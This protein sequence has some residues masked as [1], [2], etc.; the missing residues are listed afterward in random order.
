MVAACSQ[1]EKPVAQ[2]EK[3][4]VVEDRYTPVMVQIGQVA[5]PSFS[6]GD[7]F[8]QLFNC[9]LV[10]EQGNAK[11]VSDS[12]AIK[13]Y[14]EIMD[15][16]M[17]ALTQAP[18]FEIK[19]S[20]QVIFLLKDN[21]A[22]AHVLVDKESMTI[23]D[24][25]FPK[26]SSIAKLGSNSEKFRQQLNGSKITFSENNFELIP[27]DE[28]TKPVGDVVVDGISGATTVCQDAVDLLNSQLPF[29]QNYLQSQEGQL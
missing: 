11:V 8:S 1:P 7:D 9:Y 20:G 4:Q 26:G 29:Y 18:I 27:W 24:I 23:A 15:G 10:D 13:R 14:L 17:D 25:Q 2:A 16:E 28:Q 3:P 22:W 6:S 19:D 12:T 5:V 21:K